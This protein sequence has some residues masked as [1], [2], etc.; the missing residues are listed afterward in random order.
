[1]LPTRD[2]GSRD[3][4]S[5]EAVGMAGKMIEHGQRG[6][7]GGN[8]RSMRWVKLMIAEIYSIY[9]IKCL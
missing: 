2:S 6:K 3:R 1:M 9:T 7:M 4:R 8:G 5:E